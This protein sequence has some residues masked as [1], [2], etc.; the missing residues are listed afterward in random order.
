LGTLVDLTDIAAVA[1][2]I[3]A[4]YTTNG[5]TMTSFGGHIFVLLNVV[6]DPWGPTN[7][8]SDSLL[9]ELDPTQS[10]TNSYVGHVKV[11]KNAFGMS[12][13]KDNGV[14]YLVIPSI[15][16]IQNFMANNGSDSRLDLVTVSPNATPTMQVQTLFQGVNNTQ[17]TD[18]TAYYDFRD[19]ACSSDGQIMFVLTGCIDQY[20]VGMFWNLYLLNSLASFLSATNQTIVDFYTNY[21]TR[22]DGSPASLIP[23]YG[24]SG[25][26]WNIIFEN[27]FNRLWFAKGS[28]LVI[29]DSTYANHLTYQGGD[30]Y[31][32]RAFN[33]NA[34]DLVGE[35]LYQASL[36]IAVP[37]RLLLRSASAAPSAA[38][39][40][41]TSSPAGYK[42]YDELIENANKRDKALEEAEAK[43]K[44]SKK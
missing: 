1:A 31:G 44:T 25:T 20:G 14:D 42:N 9:I 12:L 36:G 4:G 38:A 2:D 5:V 40:G 10:G 26:Y 3:P 32:T 27:R 15:G 41:T 18:T 29:S 35:M 23:G 13:L 7:T 16:G 37:T 17:V 39:I 33:W 28:S 19:V 21:A 24:A 34:I 30:L 43:A 6:I 22:V 11:G 8:Y